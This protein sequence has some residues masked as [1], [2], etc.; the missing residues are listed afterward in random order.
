LSVE[1]GTG[2]LAGTSHTV[3]F[4]VGDILFVKLTVSK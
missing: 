3:E 4:A 1:L 2:S